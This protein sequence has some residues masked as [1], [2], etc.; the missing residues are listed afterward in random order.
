MSG[1]SRHLAVTCAQFLWLAAAQA[2][3]PV[4][5]P[6]ST[7]YVAN[8]GQAD[9]SGSS[10]TV[11]DARH[12]KVMATIDFGKAGP[13]YPIASPDGKYLWVT[14]D[15]YDFDTGGCVG[16]GVSIVRLPTMKI[17][18]TLPLPQCPNTLVFSP[19]GKRAYTMSAAGPV[20]VI[21]TATRSIVASIAV[22]SGQYD[23]A[24]SRD[25]RWLYAADAGDA[26]LTVIDTR[27]NKPVRQIALYSTPFAIMLTPDG[28]QAFVTT[29]SSTDGVADIDLR[30]GQVTAMIPPAVGSTT[31]GL[32]I[33]PDGKLLLDVDY[34]A[35]TVWLYSP[36]AQSQIGSIA[37]INYPNGIALSPSGDL[38]YVT[39][40]NC[41]AFPCTSDGFVT[42]LSTRTHT[43][44][45]TV[46]VGI[47]PQFI[48]MFSWR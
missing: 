31:N 35:Q 9:G 23:I 4:W 22:S 15:L 32:A 21:D 46:N 27:S 16:S 25:G 48:T 29:L 6:P 24:L 11:I 3:V 42:V 14:Q 8:Q 47:N 18:T 2:Q 1:V 17:E 7:L 30:T 5:V 45:G 44:L 33:T 12:L 13:I 10:V 19:D 20:S 43:V 26:N 34:S 40:D 28:H 38:A 39:D 36:P 37:P 41:A